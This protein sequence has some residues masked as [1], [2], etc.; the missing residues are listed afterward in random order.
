MQQVCHRDRCNITLSIGVAQ[1]KNV[2]DDLTACLQRADAALYEA[3]Q[4]GRNQVRGYGADAETTEQ[5]PA[6]IG[7]DGPPPIDWCG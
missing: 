1:W 6:D 5:D 7:I 2:E 3:K 4:R